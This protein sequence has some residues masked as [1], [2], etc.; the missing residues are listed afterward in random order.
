MK[1]GANIQKKH[2][3][4]MSLFLQTNELLTR[5]LISKKYMHYSSLVC[6]LKNNIYL[7]MSCNNNN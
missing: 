3:I 5:V 2:T 6:R 4:M 7:I 1:L